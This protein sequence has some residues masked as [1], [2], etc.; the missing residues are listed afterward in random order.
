MRRRLMNISETTQKQ[1]LNIGEVQKKSLTLLS[2]TDTGN[3]LP[4]NS[5]TESTI[6]KGLIYFHLR[7]WCTNK[8]FLNFGNKFRKMDMPSLK[9]VTSLKMSKT[10]SF[11]R[12][13]EDFP[14]MDT[15]Y[16]LYPTY[17]NVKSMVESRFLHLKMLSNFLQ[18]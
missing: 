5:K 16:A 3:G 1:K 4:K 9:K 6:K 18:I 2:N 14:L 11:W 8:M 12:I 10:L 7:Q 17:K 13:K 15:T